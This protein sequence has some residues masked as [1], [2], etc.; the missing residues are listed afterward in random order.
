MS[1]ASSDQARVEVQLKSPFQLRAMGHFEAHAGGW[2]LRYAW[3]LQIRGAIMRG[4][5]EAAAHNGQ[6]IAA[7]T[8]TRS[9]VSRSP[10]RSPLVLAP[11]HQAGHGCGTPTCQ[12]D[13]QAGDS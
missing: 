4:E 7:W 12:A 11:R 10:D 13:H 9:L 5:L 3:S 8:S 2:Y 6:T 1:A